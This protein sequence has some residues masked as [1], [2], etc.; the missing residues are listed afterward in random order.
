MKV[1]MISYGGGHSN[2]MA[3]VYKEL[4]KRS[5][6]DIIYAALTGA[7]LKLQGIDIKFVTISELAKLLP[8]Y[9]D[10]SE[11]GRKYGL[12]FHNAD[13]GMP[14]ED[15]IC[16]YGIGMHDLIL[17]VGEE[18]A[19]RRLFENNRKAFLPVE[20]M[21][22]LLQII[23]PDVCVI[24]SSP[25]MEK[26]TGIAAD[27][28]GIPV[29]RINDLPVCEPIAHS[30]TL[31]VMN[32]WAKN[33]AVSNA[34]VSESD[35]YVTGQPTFDADFDVEPSYIERIKKDS[36]ATHFSNVVTFFAENGVDQSTELHA[37]FGTAERMAN[38]LFVIKL[39]PNQPINIYG[40]PHFDNVYITNGD[41]KPFF[42]FSDLVITTFSTT[43]M[44]AALFGIPV[45][46]INYDGRK[47]WPDY[48]EMGIAVLCDKPELQEEMIRT[49][50][51]RNRKEY[52]YLKESQK[53]FMFVRNAA[54]NICDVIEK[55]SSCMR[56]H[57]AEEN[58]E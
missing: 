14:V 18:E 55:M 58:G 26:A 49:Y 25:R 6:L 2:I 43:G 47:Y 37:L 4:R 54:G 32:E 11:L 23:S 21:K 9:E 3:S 44:E 10:V 19:E 34:G 52:K 20:T 5:G 16:Y 22:A 57:D 24:T 29:I 56:N 35:I 38:T 15:T 36:G 17:E 1:F 40:N 33:Y 7:A 13:F 41:A 8:F 48:I 31:C 27:Q 46:V 53:G 50:L 30:C 45:I 51:D 39:H 12:P 28:L 42:H